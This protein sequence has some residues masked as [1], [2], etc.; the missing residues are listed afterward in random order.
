M[1]TQ[2]SHKIKK[3]E[4]ITKRAP[5]LVCK[6]TLKGETCRVCIEKMEQR[7]P[8]TS[9]FASYRRALQLLAQ[10]RSTLSPHGYSTLPPGCPR[11]ATLPCNRHHKDAVPGNC[12]VITW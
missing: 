10:G 11:E 8:T 9:N 5:G 1:W 7:I 3:L 2:A 12:L 6:N 4:A